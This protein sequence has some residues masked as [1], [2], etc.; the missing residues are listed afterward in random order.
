MVGYKVVI[1]LAGTLNYPE[2]LEEVE[3]LIITLRNNLSDRLRIIRI[4]ELASMLDVLP[5]SQLACVVAVL[6]ADQSG[7]SDPSGERFQI[8]S[9]FTSRLVSLLPDENLPPDTFELANQLVFRPGTDEASFVTKA[10]I[11]WDIAYLLGY[12][13]NYL[14]TTQATTQLPTPQAATH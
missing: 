6:L 9:S 7:V 14:P 12:K 1:E 2:A 4:N 13:S 10:D 3:S 8:I 11:A 5:T